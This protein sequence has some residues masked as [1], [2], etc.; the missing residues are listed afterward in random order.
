M[1]SFQSWCR[2]CIPAACAGL[3]LQ[4]KLQHH[5]LHAQGTLGLWPAQQTTA[6]RPD[7]CALC[8]QRLPTRRARRQWRQWQQWAFPGKRPVSTTALH[9]CSVSTTAEQAHPQ[10]SDPVP[11]E[12]ASGPLPAAAAAAAAGGSPQAG[13][14]Q[15]QGVTGK[16]GSDADSEED[17]TGCAALCT[18]VPMG[19]ATDCPDA[20]GTAGTGGPG[21]AP[22][23]APC[24]WP[25]AQV[26]AVLLVS[27]LHGEGLQPSAAVRLTCTTP[28]R[29]LWPPAVRVSGVLWC[30]CCAKVQRSSIT[31]F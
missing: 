14:P 1:R 4:L 12:T 24:W 19:V 31:A 10:Q 8:L 22:P 16:A 27:W 25:A 29:S 5:A 18:Q 30:L 23:S 6:V 11:A 21:L 26:S 28:F 7:G 2:A 9:N 15:A 17:R 13:S 3:V 20:G